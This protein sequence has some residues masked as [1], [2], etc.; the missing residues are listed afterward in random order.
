MLTESLKNGGAAKN[1]L[2]V[3]IA[4]GVVITTLYGMWIDSSA[5]RLMAHEATEYHSGI[6]GIVNTR[7][8]TER[9]WNEDQNRK[10]ED[11][12]SRALE[13]IREDVQDVR[14]K[15]VETQAV[16]KILEERSR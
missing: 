16:L 2:G 10:I 6:I 11:R 7:M 5:D 13:F 1:I 9:S 15:I 12:T 14:D 8:S 3:A 4:L